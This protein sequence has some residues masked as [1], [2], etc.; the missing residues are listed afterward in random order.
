[1]AFNLVKR[2]GPHLDS[3]DPGRLSVEERE[4]LSAELY[5]VQSEVFS[6]V[7]LAQFR[8][9]VIEAKATYTRVLVARD[10]N[11]R[12]VGYLATHRYNRELD[13]AP[14][15]ILRA[16]TGFSRAWRGRSIFGR[17]FVREVLA[18]LIAARGRPLY[19]MGS[20]VHPTSYVAITRY[21]ASHWPRPDMQTPQAVRSLLYELAD[22][23]GLQTVPGRDPLVR[24][25]GWCTRDTEEEQDFWLRSRRPDVRCFVEL[26]PEFSKGQGLLT[27]IPLTV[28]NVAGGIA[29]FM[30]RQLGRK[31]PPSLRA[32]VKAPQLN[33]PRARACLDS[34][35]AF[36]D[37]SEESRQTL[38]SEA[39]M[40][41]F[42]AGTQLI[43]RGESPGPVYLIAKGA[44]R[45]RVPGQR[46]SVIADQLDAGRL[47]GE[48]GLMTG[49][50][51]QADVI[52]ATDVVLWQLDG[53][54]LRE[55]AS[56]DGGL[57]EG[58]W[59][60]VARRHLENLLISKEEAAK[61]SRA[62]RLSWLAT[63][64]ARSVVFAP[65]TL[66]SVASLVV[67]SKLRAAAERGLPSP[68]FMG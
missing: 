27:L 54:V 10:D 35:Q 11:G 40:R 45:V 20:L 64:D 47:I 18:A 29:Q 32:L 38:A 8:R 52:A 68:A 5:S 58:L 4:R 41:V 25:V 59:R 66:G 51:C 46:A 12:V 55:M 57:N 7:D 43:N 50:P 9:Y 16:E 23:F 39:K 37:A 2:S 42:P 6:G 44:V 17:H 24:E 48:M 61:L 3:V 26:N 21:V 15:V 34:C 60:T 31:F 65:H 19:F 28:A 14:C 30:C 33:P 56:L 22:S 67:D 53:Q 63:T 13:G 62:K 1:M 36:A 49:T